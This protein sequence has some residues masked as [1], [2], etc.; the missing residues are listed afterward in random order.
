MNIQFLDESNMIKFEK[1]I[2]AYFLKG[3]A[4]SLTGGHKLAFGCFFDSFP[5]GFVIAEKWG[6]GILMV[7]Y[8]NV[9]EKYRNSGIGNALIKR[10]IKYA[11]DEKYEE[12]YI[13]HYE[14]REWTR[15]AKKLFFKNGFKE[16]GYIRNIFIINVSERV[17]KQFSEKM[18]NR[19]SKYLNVEG[20]E[21]RTFN[22]LDDDS[23]NILNS[24]RGKS[25][26][27]GFYPLKIFNRGK[28]AFKN[29]PS[30]FMLK[31]DIPVG[32]ITYEKYGSSALLVDLIYL[33][34]KYRKKG[35]FIPLIYNS[36]K[37][38]DHQ[39]KK[40]VFY[41]NGDNRGMLGVTDIFEEYITKKESLIEY[42][43][44]I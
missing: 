34:E 11:F 10:L 9:E 18:E 1:L 7:N 23:V 28:A 16:S 42:V 12:I 19:Y 17:L 36:I 38:I 37:N 32:W 44:G 39:I 22:Q 20:Y 13:S 29:N 35:L 4:N 2:P 43:R 25:Y 27:E 3:F 30:L 6:N 40:M 31:N 41:V 21:F 24:S 33:N 26:P 15:Y 14:N 5:A 8:F